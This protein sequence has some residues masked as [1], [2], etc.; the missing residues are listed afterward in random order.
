VNDAVFELVEKYIYA[1]SVL[2]NIFIDD[3]LADDVVVI[4]PLFIQLNSR[5]T[6][7]LQQRLISSR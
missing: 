6:R 5:E 4:S 7:E 1:S 2:V 3:A